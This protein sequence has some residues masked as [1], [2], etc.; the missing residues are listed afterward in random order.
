MSAN[1]YPN[2]F[3]RQIKVIV[4]LFLYSILVLLLIDDSKKYEKKHKNDKLQY[5]SVL[6]CLIDALGFF[7]TTVK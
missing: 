5:V 2:I 7:R 1:K 3:S 6:V 4:Y